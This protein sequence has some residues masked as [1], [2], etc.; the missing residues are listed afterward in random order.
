MKKMFYPLILA[1]AFI[2]CTAEDQHPKPPADVPNR[3][4]E[5]LEK[6]DKDITQYEKKAMQDEIKSMGA[7]RENYSQFAKEMEG[8]EE[9]EEKVREL[10]LEKEA[11]LNT[12]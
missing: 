6:I 7:F 3:V 8:S 5:R 10:Q 4:I 9:N 1:C 2:G 12:K 11:L